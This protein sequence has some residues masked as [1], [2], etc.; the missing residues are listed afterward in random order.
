MGGSSPK[1]ASAER[2]G[3]RSLFGG[4][5]PMPNT[6]LP[7]A[8]TLSVEGRTAELAARLTA[9]AAQS[10]VAAMIVRTP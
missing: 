5:T 9:C 4:R 7:H 1:P 10:G 6:L 8:V 3:G 2:N